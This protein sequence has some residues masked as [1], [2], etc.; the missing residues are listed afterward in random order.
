MFAIEWFAQNEGADGELLVW[1]LAGDLLG[2]PAGGG[3][4]SVVL[5]GGD[6]AAVLDAAQGADAMAPW[7]MGDVEPKMLVFRPLFD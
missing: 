4:A 5:T 1:P 3:Y 2:A 6:L 7:D